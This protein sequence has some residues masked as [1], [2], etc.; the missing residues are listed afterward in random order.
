MCWKTIKNSLSP[1]ICLPVCLHISLC[2]SISVCNCDWGIDNW[3]ENYCSIIS[4]DCAL[5][6]LRVLLS[7][8]QR[9]LLPP[10]FSSLISVQPVYVVQR[11]FFLLPHDEDIAVSAGRESYAICK[12]QSGRRYVKCT[13]MPLDTA[14]VAVTG[15]ARAHTHTLTHTYI[16]LSV[17]G[18]TYASLAWA[19]N[20]ASWQ[21]TATTNTWHSQWICEAHS[22][23][24]SYAHS[25]TH[26]RQLITAA[27]AVGLNNASGQCC[28][29]AIWLRLSM[30]AVSVRCLRL[31]FMPSCIQG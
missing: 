16:E 19:A 7:G 10:Y 28:V 27:G 21:A 9:V 30:M 18:R 11:T 6:A 12:H 15:S 25:C 8:T 2:P 29:Y 4:L 26:S 3:G 14:N 1:T 23:T 13:W 20:K 17:R 24:H 22:H 31:A 5:W